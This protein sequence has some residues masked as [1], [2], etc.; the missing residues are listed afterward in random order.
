MI[1]LL[2][3]GFVAGLVAGI[4][5]CIVPVL[6]VVLAAGA[7]GDAQSRSDRAK[8]RSAR[9][10]PVAVVGGLVL[11]FSAA[12]LGG[13]ALLSVLGLPQDLLRD[14]GLVLVGLVGLGLLVP[15][16]GH[17]IERPFSRLHLRPPTGRGSGFV[18]GLGLGALFVPCAGPVLTAISV[19]AA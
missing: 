9:W 11:S 12:T 2:G 6:P 3:I 4:S 10:R 1:G 13:S 18:L 16:V 7:T 15:T 19:V 17:V 8:A 5:P 14:V